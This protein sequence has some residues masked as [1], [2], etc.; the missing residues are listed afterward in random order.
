[1]IIL[2]DRAVCSSLILFL[3]GLMFTFFVHC[4]TLP[5]ICGKNIRILN[6]LHISSVILF[7]VDL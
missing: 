7:S 3:I 1:M 2:F 6:S 4:F 5:L